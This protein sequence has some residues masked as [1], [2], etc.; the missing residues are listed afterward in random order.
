VL[1]HDANLGLFG[2][3]T[4]LIANITGTQALSYR[5]PD[6]SQI[7]SLF[8]LSQ[9][10]LDTP[11][12]TVLVELKTVPTASQWVTLGGRLLRMG[13]RVWVASFDPAVTAAAKAHGYQTAQIDAHATVRSAAAVRAL[14]TA[15]ESEWSRLTPTLVSQLHAAGVT[16]YAYTADTSTQW[17]R[18][19]SLGV[20]PITDDPTGFR[21][22]FRCPA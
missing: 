10:V 5:A 22:W 20:L 16:V 14:G 4:V 2:A 19:V 13:T 8:S 11:G 21:A 17:E 6:G 15:Y 1:L 7:E 3:P 18:V 12:Q 9:Q